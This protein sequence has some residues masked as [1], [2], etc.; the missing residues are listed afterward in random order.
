MR[1]S[2]YQLSSI[3]RYLYLFIK[4]L[5]GR[6]RK[7]W[8]LKEK[9]TYESYKYNVSFQHEHIFATHKKKL[10]YWLVCMP[11]WVSYFLPFVV[12]AFVFDFYFYYFFISKSSNWIWW[13][14]LHFFF[15]K[16]VM[17]N[18]TQIMYLYSGLRAI[19]RST[20]VST[21][22]E[23]EKQECRPHLTCIFGNN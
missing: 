22:K 6:Y 16:L 4:A 7:C 11:I 9:K 12:I 19:E 17:L 5:I 8:V 1:R 13:H 18:W 20:I 2:T 10:W 14:D 15:M 3:H 23:E 21:K